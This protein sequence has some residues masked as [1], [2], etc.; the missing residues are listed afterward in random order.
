MGPPSLR[1]SY[2]AV[3]NGK[4]VS[5]TGAAELAAEVPLPIGG[6]V[7]CPLLPAGIAPDRVAAAGGTLALDAASR[8]A[9]LNWTAGSRAMSL[10]YADYSTAD[11][12]E[13]ARTM[14]E[15]ADGAVRLVVKLESASTQTFAESDFPIPPRPAA[16]LRKGG[17]Q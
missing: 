8:P 17:Q 16:A 6:A 15:S 7:G 11:G 2:T 10:A 12:P 3:A 14:T 5:I 9:R 13:L 4:R 1:R